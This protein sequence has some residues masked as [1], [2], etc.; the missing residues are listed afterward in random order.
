MID[1]PTAK[2]QYELRVRTPE[3]D[4]IVC[5]HPGF[6]GY[7]AAVRVSQALGWELAGCY[8]PDRGPSRLAGD[9]LETVGC[10]ARALDQIPDP[11]GCVVEVYDVRTRSVLSEE[12]VAGYAAMAGATA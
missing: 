5:D 4:V 9:V 6:A 8:C 12:P 7:T 1:K 11:V 10:L 2:V 3:G